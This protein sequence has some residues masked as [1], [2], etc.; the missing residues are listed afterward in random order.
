MK[1]DAVAVL[2]PVYNGAKY[3]AAAIDSVLAQS[4]AV[5]EILV[6]DD[7]STD[8][9]PLI[10][11]GYAGLRCIVL[12]R[13]GGQAAALNT[14]VAASTA[15]WLAFLDSD[16]LW[17]PDKLER[18]FAAVQARPELE[19]VCGYAEQFGEEPHRPA[20]ERR[21]LPA[22]LPSAMLLRR[23]AWERVG[24][25]RSDSPTFIVD[26][27][28][29]A[30]ALHLETQMLDTVCYRRRL[31]AGN[32]GRQQGMREAYLRLIAEKLERSRAKQVSGGEK[33]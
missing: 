30:D 8:A 5:H 21:L 27:W 4:H 11:Q 26:W 22:R 14:G 10:A 25:F 31:H 23:S 29:R 7:G 13:N 16:D 17:Q 12:P 2:I 32:L 28:A 6:I 3:L 1:P 33:P 15:P 9:S 20:A 19:A 18:Q 24:A